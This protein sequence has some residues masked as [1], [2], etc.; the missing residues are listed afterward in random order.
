MND[1]GFLMKKKSPKH[2][3]QVQLRCRGAEFVGEMEK[4]NFCG[5]A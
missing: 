2:L 3:A 1:S 4:S 5:E